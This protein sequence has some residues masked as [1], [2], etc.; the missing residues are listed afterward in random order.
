MYRRL[1]RKKHNAVPPLLTAGSFFCRFLTSHVRLHTSARQQAPP[2]SHRGYNVVGHLDRQVVPDGGRVFLVR[3]RDKFAGPL[4]EEAVSNQV[5]DLRGVPGG[6][7][8][9]MGGES[10]LFWL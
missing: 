6:D 9:D 10:R 8:V 7:Q 4:A 2:P 3:V 5:G 1:R